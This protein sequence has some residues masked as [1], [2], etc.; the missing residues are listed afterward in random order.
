[1]GSF[2]GKFF[3]R[4]LNLYLL[5]RNPDQWKTFQASQK[6]A[7]SQQAGNEST[8]TAT[9]TAVPS[10]ASTAGAEPHPENK[11]KRKERPGDEID[12]LFEDK[13]GKKVKKGEL[14]METP[15]KAPEVEEKH[16][17]KERREKKKRRGEGDDAKVLQDVLGAIKAA[18]KDDK[19]H[20][21]KK[22]AQ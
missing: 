9:T 7:A 10:A 8:K 13:L 5:Q 21:K 14:K 22:K 11:K 12:Q 3:L 16:E 4:N 18:P 2:Y 6:A 1:M 17:K 19:R 20:H 15:V